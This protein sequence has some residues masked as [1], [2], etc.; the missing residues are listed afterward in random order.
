VLGVNSGTLYDA[1]L[2]VVN[3]DNSGYIEKMPLNGNG[4]EINNSDIL[5]N[6]NSVLGYKYISQCV[7]NSTDFVFTPNAGS[8]FQLINSTPNVSGV[9]LVTDKTRDPTVV[10]ISS[11]TKP[12]FRSDAI[13]TN[14]MFSSIVKTDIGSN[15]FYT[16]SS[17]TFYKTVATGFIPGD[18]FFSF[19]KFPSAEISSVQGKLCKFTVGHIT[20][21]VHSAYYSIYG[22]AAYQLMN[23]EGFA[24][25]ELRVKIYLYNSYLSYISTAGYT[26][27]IVKCT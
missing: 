23:F 17:G 16:T 6:G 20:Q 19:F 5:I 22:I 1:K 12:I 15:E 26:I 27:N 2:V 14:M 7:I 18:M 24:N 21:V 11:G 9:S 13:E 25:G 10:T 4:I 8:M 3:I